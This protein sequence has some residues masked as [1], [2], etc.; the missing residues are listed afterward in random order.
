MSLYYGDGLNGDVLTETER[1]AAYARAADGSLV[2]EGVPVD[3]GPL[4]RLWRL[5]TQFL[6]DE[7]P[8]PLPWLAPW[9][10]WGGLAWLLWK[11]VRR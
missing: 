8:A 6:P 1:A 7:S 5:P 3:N 9:I 4:L 2:P 10:V 11:L